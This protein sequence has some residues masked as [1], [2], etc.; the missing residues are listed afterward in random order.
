MF[1]RSSCFIFFRLVLQFNV[2]MVNHVKNGVII[3]MLFGKNMKKKICLFHHLIY[4]YYQLVILW[5]KVI[6]ILLKLFWKSL[7]SWIEL[8]KNIKNDISITHNEQFQ[9]HQQ[10]IAEKYWKTKNKSS[11]SILDILNNVL[12]EYFFYSQSTTIY[13]SSM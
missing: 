10:R 2:F 11:K 8:N 5:R 12:I 9:K 6:E 4:Y 1:C 13:L 3:F 7:I